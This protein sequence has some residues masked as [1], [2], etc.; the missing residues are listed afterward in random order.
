[1]PSLYR[2]L[3]LALALTGA[4]ASDCYHSVHNAT[5]AFFSS[6][7]ITFSYEVDTAAD[8][9]DWCGR[10][11]KC[12]AWLYVNHA[13]ECDLYRA[14]SLTVAENPGF[15]FGG[16]APTVED[17]SPSSVQTTSSAVSSGSASS[18]LPRHHKHVHHRHGHR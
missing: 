18:I 5:I 9:L 6:A 4:Q 15:V 8:C 13:R 14:A 3:F 16:C 10:V 7:A 11:E 17:T 1:M 12:Q 2:S